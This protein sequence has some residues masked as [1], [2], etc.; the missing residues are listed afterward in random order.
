MYFKTI[1]P[2][3]WNTACKEL[4]STDQVMHNLI[5]QYSNNKL[6]SICNPFYSLSKSIV[7]QQ[8]SVA[9]ASAIWKR[10]EKKYD[11]LGGCCFQIGDLKDLRKIGLSER[12]ALYLIGL[13]NNLSDFN[14]YSYWTNLNDKEVFSHLIKYKGIG[15]WSIKMFQIFCLNRPDIFSCDDLGLI[16]AIGNNYFNGKRIDKNKADDFALKW[17]PWRT[18]ASWFLWRSIDPEI[19]LY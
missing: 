2:V 9:A 15:P 10:L 18:A 13:S 5:T 3:W 7:G 1:N 12:K 17:K 16:R 19:V 8:I 4:A 6:S 14:S 11:I